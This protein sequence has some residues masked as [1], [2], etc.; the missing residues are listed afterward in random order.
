MS[1]IIAL[2]TG[3]WSDQP[4][5]SVAAKANE[6]GYTGLDLACWGDHLAIQRALAEPEYCRSILA[7]LEQHELT[8]IS[9]SN[10]P[11]GQAVSDRLDARHQASLPEWIWGEGDPDGVATRAAQEM[12]ETAKVAQQLGISLVVAATGSPFTAMHFGFPPASDEMI[13]AGWQQFH[14]R[15]K[16]ILDAFDQHG[17]KLAIELN[18]A[19]TAFDIDSAQAT[20]E[21]LESHGALTF[22]VNP[23]QLHWL[24]VDPS[25]FIRSQRDRLGHV[26]IQDAVV[27]LTGRNSLIGSLWPMGYPR[28]G[29]NTRMPGQGN[30]DWP[31]LLRTLTQ[32]H[33][34]GPLTIS[35][36][37]AEVD[38]D[39]AASEAIQL[40]RRLDFPPKPRS[41]GIFG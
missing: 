23:A 1:R 12:V 5:S 34:S 7:T 6:W 38:A 41:D 18:P 32:V 20:V 40:I 33:Y 37:D 10:Q 4:L 3:P 2:H 8:L 22:A 21:A 36:Q 27:S 28:R 16:P 31:T 9:I 29:W 35:I 30:V 17:C 11:V 25:E 26:Y 19:Q 39:Y 24:G 13:T 14:Q 15:W